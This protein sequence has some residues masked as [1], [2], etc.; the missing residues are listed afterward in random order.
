MADA[1]TIIADAARRYGVEPELAV[2]IAAIESRLNAHAKNPKSSAGGF[3]QFIDSTWGSY[4][5]G[6]NKFDGYANADAGARFMGFMAATFLGS[7][8]YAGQTHLNL[9]GDERREEK[10]KDRM[11]LENLALA[12]FQRSSE[13]SLL[14]I[15]V[16]IVSAMLTGDTLFDF[17]SS[18]LKSDITSLF[19]NPTGDLMTIT[20]QGV[21]GLATAALGDDYSQSDARKLFQ[22]LPAQRVIGAQWFFNWLSS[23]LPQREFPND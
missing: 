1:R 6:K 13:S 10:L 20:Y 15:P 22:A 2:D 16:D 7:L 5:N 4:G 12:G 21:Q 8:V 17:R 14:P 9:L 19:G 23:G 18:G 11:S 3:F